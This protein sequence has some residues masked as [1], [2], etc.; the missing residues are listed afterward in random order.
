MDDQGGVTAKPTIGAVELEERD[1]QAAIIDLSWILRARVGIGLVLAFIYGVPALT[2]HESVGEL[3]QQALFGGLFVAFLFVS[4]RLRARRLLRSIAAGGDRHASY[5]FDDDGVTFRTAG[6]TTT[7]AYRSLVESR[8]GKTA[9]FVYTAPGVANI[10]P[11]RAFTPEGLARVR[12]L[13]AANVKAARLSNA[14]RLFVLW[15]AA[16]LAF[17]VMWQF[18]SSTSGPP[19]PSPP[20]P[21]EAR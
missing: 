11:K 14:N 5:R 1:L 10:V 7:A 12:A 17:F 2:A 4:P 6:S 20:T 19:R 15:F 9:L 16:I 8:E 13:L 3:A 21:T 18:L